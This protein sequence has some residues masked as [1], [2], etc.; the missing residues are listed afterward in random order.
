MGQRREAVVMIDEDANQEMQLLKEKL[1][2]HAQRMEKELEEI[3]MAITE[4]LHPKREE[5]SALSSSSD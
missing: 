2:E 3:R 1:I 4:A 5:V